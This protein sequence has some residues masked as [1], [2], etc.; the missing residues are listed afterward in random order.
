MIYT[1]FTFLSITL[2]FVITDSPLKQSGRNIAS[3]NSAYGY[4]TLCKIKP[5]NPRSKVDIVII[6]NFELG[7]ECKNKILSPDSRI[8]GHGKLVYNIIQ[9]ESPYSRKALI[10]VNET[11]NGIVGA[12]NA[13]ILLNPRI[14]NISMAGE[15]YDIREHAAIK[16]ASDRGILIIAASGNN[17]E[18]NS[19]CSY[20]AC[21]KEVLSIGH[22]GENETT[23][24][25]KSSKDNIDFI[26]SR[27]FGKFNGS[28][29]GTALV[30][31]MI[32]NLNNRQSKS[33]AIKYLAQSS[34]LSSLSKYGIVKRENK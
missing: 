21:Y 11:E 20:P 33:Q 17:I 14:I 34:R 10:S 18:R 1:I 8:Y 12:I 16:K 23:I 24:Y 13:A 7:E 6:D 28:S 19:D 9:K 25:S 22:M 32:A 30:T 27:D 29:L 4:R 26:V 5:F 2:V 31:G 15:G 3:M